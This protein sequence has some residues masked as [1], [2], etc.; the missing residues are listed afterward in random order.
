MNKGKYI[1]KI[2]NVTAYDAK[3]NKRRDRRGI[4]P[5]RSLLILL[6]QTCPCLTRFSDWI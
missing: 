3:R 1:L 2:N 4:L 5:D 6:P